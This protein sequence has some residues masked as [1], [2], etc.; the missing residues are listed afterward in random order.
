MPKEAELAVEDAVAINV[1]VSGHGEIVTKTLTPPR[2]GF[3]PGDYRVQTSYSNP[4]S[5]S[6]EHQPFAT[7]YFVVA[8]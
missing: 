5:G 6:P 3:C 7:A 4:E 2:H 1:V 8:R